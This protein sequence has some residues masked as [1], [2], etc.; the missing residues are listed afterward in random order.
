MTTTQEQVDSEVKVHIAE[1]TPSGGGGKGAGGGEGGGE[2]GGGDG[3]GE[4][5]GGGLGGGGMGGWLKGSATLIPGNWCPVLSVYHTQAS[6]MPPRWKK[7][8]RV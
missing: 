8:V 6:V 3:G 5:G 7:W 1:M 2:G 4:G